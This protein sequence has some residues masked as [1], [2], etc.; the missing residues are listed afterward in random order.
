[1]LW[2]D[3]RISG[4]HWILKDQ[5]N[6]FTINCFRFVPLIKKPKHASGKN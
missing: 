3:L 6:V 4:I 2:Q 5:K 1:M